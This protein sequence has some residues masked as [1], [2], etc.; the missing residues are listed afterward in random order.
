MATG[1]GVIIIAQ[2]AILDEKQSGTLAWV[3][4]KPVTR[5]AFFVAKLLANGIAII[6]IMVVLQCAVAYIQLSLAGEQALP[7]LPFLG[8]ALLMGLYL[9][10]FLTLTLMLSA[11]SNHR[12]VA[13]GVPMGLNFGY[14]FIAGVAPW[15][16]EI[17]PFRLVLT[18]GQNQPALAVSLVMQ[19]SIT[20]LL[21]I[22]ATVVWIVVFIVIGLWKF[23]RIEF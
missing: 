14:Q 22:I 20:S 7:L 15:L 9:L 13:I 8:G 6:L 12:G 4:S 16:G 1:V 21:P 23:R 19:Q 11:V 5:T 10:F 18:V 3:L 17:M 2:G